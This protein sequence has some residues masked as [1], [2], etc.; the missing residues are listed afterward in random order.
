MLPVVGDILM[1]E[2]APFVAMTRKALKPFG[3]VV[4][5]IG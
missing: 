3:E 5:R 4:S 1:H 2:V